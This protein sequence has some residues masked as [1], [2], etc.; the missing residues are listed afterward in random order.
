MKPVNKWL[1]SLAICAITFCGVFMFLV[2]PSVGQD[3]EEPEFTNLQ[4][5][6]ED[7]DPDRL[8]DI[9]RSISGQLG[10]ECD[11]CHVAYG[12]DDPRNDF[13]SDSKQPKLVARLM[14]ENMNAF[15]QALTSEALDK[16]EDDIERVQCS[17]CHQGNA[18]P[19]VF[20]IPED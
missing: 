6:P 19:P 11:H 4:L 12:R 10:V 17:S 1:K 13:A 5:L 14:V 8:T 9:M 7:I 20:E 3:E 15:N 16:L 18:I 2:Q